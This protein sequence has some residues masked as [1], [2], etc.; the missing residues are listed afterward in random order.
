M[1]SNTT[2]NSLTYEAS[3]ASSYHLGNR[4]EL[5]RTDGYHMEISPSELPRTNRY[6]MEISPSE[7]MAHT[8]CLVPDVCFQD[9][10]ISPSRLKRLELNKP[11]RRR[12]IQ[13]YNPLE[14]NHLLPFMNQRDFVNISKNRN[15]PSSF[16][17]ISAIEDAILSA[18]TALY[19]SE[20]PVNGD[21]A[22]SAERLGSEE[23]LW[24]QIQESV[25]LDDVYCYGE[26]TKDTTSYESILHL[27]NFIDDYLEGRGENGT[28]NMHSDRKDQL[29]EDQNR[30]R[31]FCRHFLKG[32]CKRGK[33][34]DFLHDP[35]IFCPNSQKV[36]LGGLPTHITE[37]TL[38]QKLAQQGYK[39]INKPKVLR[40]FTPQ[41]C[42][43]SIEEAQKLIEKRNILIDGSLVDVRPYE[44]FVKGGIDESRPDETKRSV[45]LGGL[46]KGTTSQ[47]IR[48]DL[49]KMDI[50][51]I[52]HPLVKTG[53]T[54]KV[55]F[56][57]VK[58]TNML[59]KLKKVR[60]NDTLVDV[61][62][63]VNKNPSKT[64]SKKQDKPNVTVKEPTSP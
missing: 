3:L 52:N 12:S 59:I 34:C 20:A 25:L 46:S 55:T 4:M 16:H 51:V 61:R 7:L 48:D 43:A 63:Y 41:V 60:I 53:F 58:E 33:A 22:Q 6:H 1:T 26:E 18:T 56:G 9:Y 15:E 5:P 54:P 37:A 50:K 62:P 45:F 17:E 35:S 13:E 21:L 42:L 14:Y 24:K 38:R 29:E 30:K 23:F 32:H 28:F 57:T 19:N 11:S 49:Q 36:F 8:G 47:M 64:S 2:N 10:S 44:A 27:H 31:G 39:V 40:G